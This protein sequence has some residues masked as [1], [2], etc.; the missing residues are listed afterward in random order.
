MANTV[1]PSFLAEAA[2]AGLSG[3]SYWVGSD[4][5]YDISQLTA[6]QQ[7]TFLKVLA[8]H[9][10]T[11]PLRLPLTAQVTQFRDARL[12]SGFADTGT[13]G[14]GK[15][16]QCDQESQGSWTALAAAAQPWAL[17]LVTTTP[18]TFAPWGTDNE[19]VTMTAAECYALFATRVMPWVNATMTYARTM[20]ANI[21]AGNP[22]ADITQ[23][24][25]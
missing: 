17:G 1:G 15:T 3:L 23:G 12:A 19:P 13:G 9:D 22:P 5:T 20:K 24:W 14:T 6:A 16:W 21:A 8:A 7:A 11:K 2:D 18:P 4:G 10:P 25:P